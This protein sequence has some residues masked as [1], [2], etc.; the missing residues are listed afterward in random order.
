MKK[1]AIASLIAIAAATAGAVEVGVTTTTDYSGSQDRQGFG[2]TVGQK[3][4]AVSVTGGFERF[5][6]GANDQDRYSVTAGYDVAKFGPVTVTPKLG[7]AYLNNQHTTDGYALTVGVG[8]SAP[9]TKQV[10]VGL[11]IARQYGQD[12][13]NAF[14]GNRVTAGVKYAF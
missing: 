7:V 9:V 5:S 1:I 13:V 4:G 10:S 11:D 14:D 12:R 8:A 3:V 2:L 6:K